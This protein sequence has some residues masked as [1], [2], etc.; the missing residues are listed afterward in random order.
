MIKICDKLKKSESE[1]KYNIENNFEN[2]KKNL[3]YK[4]ASQMNIKNNL[5]L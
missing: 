1:R 2:D 4:I 5:D 3:S